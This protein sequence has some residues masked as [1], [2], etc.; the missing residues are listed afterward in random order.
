LLKLLP[1]LLALPATAIGQWTYVESG[2]RAELR[3]LSVVSPEVIWAS[4]A[5]GTVLRSVDG[6]RTWT[7]IVIP[8]AV[9]LDLRAIH[10]FSADAAVAASAGEAEKGLARVYVTRDGGKQ[11][12][13]AYRTD[14]KGV[15][16][17]AVAF[18]NARDG[19]LLSDPVDGAFALLRSRDGG[20]SWSRVPPV[21]LPRVLPGEAAFAASGSVLVTADTADLWIGTGGGGRARVMHSADRGATWSTTE[22]PV[23]AEGPASGIFSLA[24]FDRRIGVAAGGDYTK[25]RLAATSLA[26][27]ADGG[28][29]WRAAK[30][31]PS[32]YLSG[33]AYAGTR[34]RLVAVGLAGSFLSQDG[35]ESWTQTD[36]VALNSVRFHGRAGVAVGPRGTI[37]RTVAP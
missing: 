11:W 33:V 26:L 28:A 24:F 25:P 18:W 15:F 12:S 32:A 16:F 13:L 27:T 19:M 29:T 14:L 4:G 20:A 30:S 22:A 5:N 21:R 37:A 10:G 31:P 3:G 34:E 17:D 7:N 23:H 9:L 2:T 36:T 6:G 1:F 8:D 35:G